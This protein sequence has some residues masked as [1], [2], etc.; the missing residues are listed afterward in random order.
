[1]NNTTIT[2]G[3]VTFLFDESRRVL[4]NEKGEEIS[5]DVRELSKGEFSVIVDGNSYHLFISGNHGTSHATMNNAVI[6]IDRETMRDKLAKQLQQ[7]SGVISSSL[8]VRA[9]MP[10]LITRI[11]KSEG[12]SVMIG[13][14]ILVVE[15]MK[16]ENEIRAPKNGIIQQIF[17][18]EKQTIE[19]ND[20]LMTIE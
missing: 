9:P 13:E 4:K 5:T 7:E 3:T 11:L 1:M 6:E 8:I 20:R 17:V 14:G 2:I 19:K 12:A 16:M 10:G 15:A 18:T